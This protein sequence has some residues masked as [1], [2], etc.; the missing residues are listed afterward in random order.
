MELTLICRWW[1]DLLSFS[2]WLIIFPDTIYWVICLFSSNVK[3]HNYHTQ[4]STVHLYSF[5]YQSCWF[6]Y[7]NVYLVRGRTRSEAPYLIPGES[8]IKIVFFIL[9]A[10]ILILLKDGPELYLS[11]CSGR[12][13]FSHTWLFVIFIFVEEFVCMCVMYVHVCECGLMYSM[14]CVLSAL[15]FLV[16][17]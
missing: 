8:V 5:I 13:G 10:I 3:Y 2:R 14:V 9:V 12:L 15:I 16:L 11:A 7:E 1:M 6:Y 17:R 4:N